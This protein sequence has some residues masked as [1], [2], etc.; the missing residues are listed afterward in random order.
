MT[1]PGVAPLWFNAA[2]AQRRVSGSVAHAAAVYYPQYQADALREL[3]PPRQKALFILPWHSALLGDGRVLITGGT[4]REGSALNTAEVFDPQKGT[5]A[6]VGRMTQARAAHVAVLLTDGRVLIAGG[7]TD[8][9]GALE[10][11]ELFNPVTNTF[12]AAGRMPTP[13]NKLAGVRL[14]SGRVLLLGGTKGYDRDTVLDSAEIFDPAS[15]Q[16]RVT[17]RMHRP[18]YKFTDAVARLPDGRIFVAG[19]GGAELY[20]EGKNQFDV[21]TGTLTGAEQFTTAAALPGGGVLVTGG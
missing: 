1:G 5:F 18:R 12:Q 11:L 13:R 16:S 7:H 19:A 4:V 10:T 15:G 6:A 9:S 17:A 20:S 2:E 3:L 21:L 14:P 8:R